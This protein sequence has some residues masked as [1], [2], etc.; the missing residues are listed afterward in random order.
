MNFV[1]IVC[2]TNFFSYKKGRKTCSKICS[3]INQQERVVGYCDFC[4]ELIKRVVTRMRGK[5]IF[6]THA[7]HHKWE[8]SKGAKF[9]QLRDKKWCQD[10]YK[11][12]SLAKIAKEIECGETTV[13]KYFKI[14]NIKL[15]RN[16]WISGEKHYL[17]KNGITPFYKAIRNRRKYFHWRKEILKINPRKCVL[18]GSTKN[19]EV[20]HIKKLKFIISDNNIKTIDDA[21]QCKELWEAKNGRILCRTCNLLREKIH[22]TNGPL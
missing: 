5:H 12:K 7:C 14:H 3:A 13:F 16:K 10:Q 8:K 11:T 15:D 20:D 21:M 22:P 19:L 18:C 1:C 2:N 6:C 17:W 4:G 9:P